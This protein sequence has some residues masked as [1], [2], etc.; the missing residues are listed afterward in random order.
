MK[1]M[2]RIALV[3][4]ITLL[5][6]CAIGGTLAWLI[7]DTVPVVNTFTS[8]DVE[9]TL[10]ESDVDNSTDDKDRDTSNS[11]KMVPGATITKDPK[12]TV[13]TGSEDCWLF[14][15][16]V[17]SAN[18][19]TYLEPYNVI[20]ATWTLLTDDNITDNNVAVYYYNENSNT[21]ATAG[22]SRYILTGDNNGSVKV[23]NGVTKQQMEAI[24]T[25]GMPTLTFT[26]YAIQKANLVNSDNSSVNTPEEAWA[27]I[28]N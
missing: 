11:Y 26:A 22:T 24:K 13:E 3:V 2:K 4:A 12:V 27:L 20:S 8:S 21:T 10:D 5:L 6:G 1:N 23:K 28:G 16:V 25:S 19:D 7:D 9:I 18:Y 15:K 14:V 17:K